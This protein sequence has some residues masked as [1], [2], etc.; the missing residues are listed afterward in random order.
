MCAFTYVFRASLDIRDVP[1]GRDRPLYYLRGHEAYRGGSW[2][3]LSSTLGPQN[4]NSR[5]NRIHCHHPRQHVSHY[6]KMYRKFLL[7]AIVP[8]ALGQDEQQFLMDGIATG[9]GNDILIPSQSRPGNVTWGASGDYVA[10]A[11]SASYGHTCALLQDK[12]I[13]CWGRNDYWQLGFDTDGVRW[14]VPAGTPPINLPLPAISVSAA[15]YSS[16]AQLND[17][18]IWCWGRQGLLGQS[19]V[20]YRLVA[21]DHKSLHLPRRVPLPGFPAP[22]LPPTATPAPTVGHILRLVGGSSDFEGRVEIFHDG[23][24]GTICDDEWDIKDA[25]VVCQQL[26]GVNA[27]EAMD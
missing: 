27:L 1:P 15:E 16:C 5:T 19:E 2:G 24:W 12:T 21:Q 20:S 13:T 3:C 14:D 6:H 17:L 22:T 9:E 18:S 8:L 23:Q 10:T 26:F 7:A 4:A 11:V 25:N